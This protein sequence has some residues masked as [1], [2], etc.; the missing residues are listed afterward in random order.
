MDATNTNLVATI[1]TQPQTKTIFKLKCRAQLVI[2][3]AR[4]LER[5]NTNARLDVTPDRLPCELVYKYRRQ[6]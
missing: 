4:M 1:E 5:S 2:F 3:D 6:R